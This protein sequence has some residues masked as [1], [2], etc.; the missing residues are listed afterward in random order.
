MFHLRHADALT[1]FDACLFCLG[2]Q[3]HW[4]GSRRVSPPHLP[5]WTVS[6]ARELLPRNPRMVF[7]YI[8]GEGTGAGSRQSWARVKAETEAAVCSMGFRDAYALRPG[9]IQPMRGARQPLS[10]HALVLLLVGSF[11]SAAAPAGAAPDHFDR[12]PSPGRW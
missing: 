5:I 10:F 7:E 12:T 9:F 8:S 1:E 2:V 4:Y 11:V 3:L 6:V